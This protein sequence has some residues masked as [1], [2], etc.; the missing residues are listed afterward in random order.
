M[1]KMK[2]H[3][4]VARRFKKTATGKVRFKR[5]RMGHLMSHKSGKQRRKLRKPSIL[6]PAIGKIIG[7]LLGKR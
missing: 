1:P 2:T 6:S 3:K 4:G 7:E 5:S